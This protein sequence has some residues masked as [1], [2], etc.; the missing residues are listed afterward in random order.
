MDRYKLIWADRPEFVRAAARYGATIIPFG[1]I[2]CEESSNS[3]MNSDNFGR[4]GDSL[5][6]LQG[7]TPPKRVAISA[8][9][10]VNA[11]AMFSNDLAMVRVCYNCL[12]LVSYKAES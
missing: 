3:I 2:G 7:R 5:A 12:H 1:G 9:K 8:R 6:Q 10:G 4:L 11:D